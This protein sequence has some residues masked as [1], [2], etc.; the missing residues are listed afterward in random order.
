MPWDTGFG[1]V[2]V[3]ME[4]VWVGAAAIPVASRCV[5]S[6]AETITEK[7]RALPGLHYSSG[8]LG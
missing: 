3:F 6:S 5:C 1:E 8:P 4:G 2:I 7:P